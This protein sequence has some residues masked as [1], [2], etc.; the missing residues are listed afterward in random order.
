MRPVTSSFRRPFSWEA[1]DPTAGSA[2]DRRSLARTFA[3]L[4]GSGATLV[5]ITLL[6]PQDGARW[7]P[8]ILVPIA[9][10]YG[11]VAACITAGER[12]PAWLFSVLPLGG[13]ILVTSVVASSSGIAAFG[14]SLLYFWVVL[15]AFF[16]FQAAWAFMNLLAVVA[17]FSVVVLV[18]HAFDDA[19][20]VLLMAAGAFTVSGSLITALRSRID[21]LIRVLRT[22]AARQAA[23]A[24]LGEEALEGT[25]PESLMV[26]AAHAAVACLPIARCDVEADGRQ[27]ATAASGTTHDGPLADLELPLRGPDGPLGVL[28]V[29]APAGWAPSL[30]ERRFL[31]TVAHLLA[32][33]IGRHDTQAALDHRARHDALTGLPNRSLFEERVERALARARMT[34]GHVAVMFVDLDGFKRVNDGYGHE[35]GDE[36]L[37]AL[38]PRLRKPL[39]V[40]DTLARFGGD[41]YVV[42]CESVDGGDEALRIAEDLRCATARPIALTGLEHRGTVSIGVAVTAAGAGEVADLLRD[43]DTA[44]YRAKELGGDRCVLFGDEL[45]DEVLSRVRIEGALRGAIDRGELSLVFQPIVDLDEGE[46]M[47]AV[48]TLARWTHPELGP[49][50]PDV[51]IAIAEQIGLI[52]RIGTWVLEGACAQLAAWAA[53]AGERA[54]GVGVNVSTVQ[55]ADPA[56]LATLERILAQ[57][58]ADPRK[59]TLEVTESVL[60]EDHPAL[61]EVLRRIRGRGIRVVL[62]D[63]GTGYSSLSYLD[64]L[65]LDSLKIDRS[66]VSRIGTDDRSRAIITAVAGIGQAFGLRMVAEGVETAE[67]AREVRALGCRFAQGYLFSRPV[68]AAEVTSRIAPLAAAA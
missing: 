39:L 37:R 40:A 51:F 46:R 25:H 44:M 12:L 30:D 55:L 29:G 31:E 63:F 8:G 35:A 36:L 34:G 17:C 7:L 53:L 26:S 19:S 11:V 32:D 22:A 65:P 4:F 13:T 28:R 14:S 5:G 49:V 27:G 2:G 58:G 21:D 48:E 62:D 1:R 59:L 10:A 24:R 6:L 64:R 23:V 47:M 18:T 16:F 20:T 50:R 67:Q 56:F 60:A 54:P 38:V 43:A 33:A 41:E 15:S 9:L 42:L 45:R 66:F 3:W 52:G 68:P 57:T 61:V